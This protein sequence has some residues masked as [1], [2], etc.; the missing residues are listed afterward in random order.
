MS[1]NDN[2]LVEQSRQWSRQGNSEDH[3]PGYAEEQQG[4]LCAVWFLSAYVRG[5]ISVQHFVEHPEQN[6]KCNRQKSQDKTH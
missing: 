2:T 6:H 3:Q 5:R 1:N 4:A